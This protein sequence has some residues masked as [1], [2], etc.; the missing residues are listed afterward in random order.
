MEGAAISKLDLEWVD[1]VMGT[2]S[3][4]CG[5]DLKCGQDVVV[6]EKPLSPE[7]AVLRVSATEETGWMIG[8]MSQGL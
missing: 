6:L 2:D 4:G 8:G 1:G 7:I 3:V 5:L